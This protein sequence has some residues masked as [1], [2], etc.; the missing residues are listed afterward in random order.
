MNT[1]ALPIVTSALFC[2]GVTNVPPIGTCGGVFVA[3]LPTTAAGFPLIFTS[4]LRAVSNVPTNGCGTITGDDGPGGWIR[5]VSVA[6]TLS[7]C[8]AAGWPMAR[9]ASCGS[10]LLSY[11]LPVAGEGGGRRPPGE[12]EGLRGRTGAFPTESPLC[13]SVGRPSPRTLRV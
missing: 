2:G 10:G 8:F 9:S 11:P 7:P 1:V 5:C 3:L 12:G 13:V 4:G 6:V